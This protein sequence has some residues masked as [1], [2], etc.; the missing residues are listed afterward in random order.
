MVVL[1]NDSACVCS[2]LEKYSVAQLCAKKKRKERKKKIWYRRES[3]SVTERTKKRK[4]GEEGRELD[5]HTLHSMLRNETTSTCVMVLLVR[6]HDGFLGK[7]P[8]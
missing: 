6:Q 1:L 7:L 3:A 2:A 4:A 5:H 8:K